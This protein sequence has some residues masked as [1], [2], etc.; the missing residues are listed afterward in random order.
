MLLCE[1]SDLGLPCLPM[2]HKKDARLIWVNIFYEARLR[3]H[4][5]QAENNIDADQ[6]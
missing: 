5:L 6:T 2:S 1:A 4:S 3:Y